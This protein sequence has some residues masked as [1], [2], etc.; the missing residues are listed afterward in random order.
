[1]AASTG[2]VSA[3]KACESLGLDKK[4]LFKMRD[5]GTLR[6]GPH[7]AAFKDTF[8]RDSYRWNL[9]SVRKELRK[10]G[11]AFADPLSSVGTTLS[12]TDTQAVNQ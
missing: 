12:S 8:S 4:T 3:N 9:N 1:M 6:L 11:I 7:Y 5:D 2:W 10:K